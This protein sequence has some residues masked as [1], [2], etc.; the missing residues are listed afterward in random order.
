M[1]GPLVIIT[2]VTDVELPQDMIDIA[3]DVIQPVFT[4]DAIQAVFDFCCI[5]QSDALT[6]LKEG[7][8]ALLLVHDTLFHC[9]MHR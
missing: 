8:A 1:G 2:Y 4:P 9:Y 3:P 7:A 6:A 5:V